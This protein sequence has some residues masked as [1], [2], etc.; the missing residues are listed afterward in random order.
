MAETEDDLGEPTRDYICPRCGLTFY[1]TIEPCCGR[2][3]RETFKR[4]PHPPTKPVPIKYG[5]VPEG[6]DEFVWLFLGGLGK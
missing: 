2:F 3:S 5:E 1:L 4:V 6:M